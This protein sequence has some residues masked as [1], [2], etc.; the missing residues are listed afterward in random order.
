[1]PF[2][3]D[4]SVAFA[5][6]IANELDEVEFNS[7]VKP[8]DDSIKLLR[9]LLKINVAQSSKVG[10]VL[11]KLKSDLHLSDKKL[12]SMAASMGKGQLGSHLIGIRNQTEKEIDEVL[13]TAGAPAA[14]TKPTAP[15]A[16]SVAQS[17]A[18]SVEAPTS[19][20]QAT[21]PTRG[22]SHTVQTDQRAV[23]R[24]IEEGRA[25]IQKISMFM[26][27]DTKVALMGPL[28]KALNLSA[29]YIKSTG[30]QSEQSRIEL[31]RAVEILKLSHGKVS[32]FIYR[33]MNNDIELQDE[34]MD[35]SKKFLELE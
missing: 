13:K 15:A 18:A 19:Q 5:K 29:S 34:F 23:S 3:I 22:A 2:I 9:S 14:R 30:L 4:Q 17:P 35:W 20:Y 24:L 16:S 8:I 1:L 26:D 7:M 27:V 25:L 10:G 32:E 28:D 6:A 31:R 21:S 12:R 33:N 11:L